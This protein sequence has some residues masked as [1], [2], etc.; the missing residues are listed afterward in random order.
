M[1]VVKPNEASRGRTEVTPTDGSWMQRKYVRPVQVGGAMGRVGLPW[2]G[3]PVHTLP[4][5]LSCL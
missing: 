4:Y 1:L 3:H 2:L 5:L